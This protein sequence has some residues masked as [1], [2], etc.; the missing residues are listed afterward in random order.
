[1]PGPDLNKGLEEVGKI[2]DDSFESG[3]ERQKTLTRRLEIDNTSPFKLPHMIRP[4]STAF[5]GAMWGI[6]VIWTLVIASILISK[7][8]VEEAS[9]IILSPDSIIMYIL[10]ATTTT[11]GTHIGFYFNSRKAEKNNAKKAQTAIE[12][13]KMREKAE[14]KEDKKMN[15]EERR[16]R[17]KG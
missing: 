14:I 6:S 4:L 3:E 5:S 8:G 15:R 17:R 10:A 11:Y 16:A 7:V 13:E 9:S 2:M 1:M 12:L